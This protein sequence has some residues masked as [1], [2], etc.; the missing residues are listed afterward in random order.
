[1]SLRLEMLQVARLATKSLGESS[2]LVEAFIRSQQNADGGYADRDGKSDLYY[3]TFAIDAL[4]ALQVELPTDALRGFL[5]SFGA[6]DGLDFVHLC[7]LARNWSAIE[8]NHGCIDAV[9][10]AIDGQYRTADGGYNQSDKATSGSAYGSFLAYG[11]YS[12]HGR[13]P[14]NLEGMKSS[15]DALLDQDEGAWANDMDLPIINV[16]ATAAAVTLYRNFREPI[17][18][19]T[20][21]WILSNLHAQG[22]FCP[23]PGTQ[24]GFSRHRSRKTCVVS[25]KVP[26]VPS[27]LNTSLSVP[28]VDPGSLS[29][30]S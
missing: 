23:F 18:D 9:L 27:K 11:A 28:L 4:T 1:M 24:S 21:G 25:T 29:V 19:K 17:P 14:P 2:E 3:T 6:G 30:K 5:E 15:L 10:A 22:G 26:P 7:C 8:K 20:P 16:P 12:D 13:M